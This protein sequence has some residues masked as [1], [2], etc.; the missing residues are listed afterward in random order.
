MIMIFNNFMK[1]GNNNNNNNFRKNKCDLPSF[2]V[3]IA[4]GV[5]ELS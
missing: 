2:Y 3:L 5:G 4:N 1:Y